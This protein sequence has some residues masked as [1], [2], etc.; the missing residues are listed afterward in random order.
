MYQNAEFASV[1]TKR[2]FVA[3]PYSKPV[4]VVGFEPL[5]ILQGVYMI[6]KQI[7]EGRCEVENQYPRVNNIAPI[8]AEDLVDVQASIMYARPRHSK[9][10]LSFVERVGA[11]VTGSAT[12]S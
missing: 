8:E 5:D 1:G 7:N 6:I 4:V 12:S 11:P 3:R 9:C 2:E 10:G